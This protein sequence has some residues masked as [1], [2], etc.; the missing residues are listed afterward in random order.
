MNKT[1]LANSDGSEIRFSKISKFDGDVSFNDF[2]FKYV[3][4]GSESYKLEKKLYTLDQNQFIIGSKNNGKLSVIIN[5][6]KKSGKLPALLFIPGYTCSSI[7]NLS[8]D[9]PYGRIVRAFSNAGYVVARIEKSGLG[10]SQNTPNCS[11]TDLKDEIESFTAGLNKLKSLSYVDTEN[12]FIFGHSMGGIIAP[13]LRAIMPVKGVM[14]YGTT[15][16]SFFEYQLEMNRLQLMLANPDP[17][18]YEKTCRLQTQIAYEYYIQK[19]ELK[20]IAISP[21]R[22]EALKTDWQYDGGNKI[23]D[24]NQEYRRQIIDNP[25]I[26]NWK[27]TRVI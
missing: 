18:V 16:K 26:E 7:D 25:L 5:K 12:I 23:F 10:D 22:I 17:L 24:R 19:K 14:V 4:K 15:A 2:S 9:H 8:L 20:D 11:S 13:A 3:V 6:P 21:E 1:I 27:N